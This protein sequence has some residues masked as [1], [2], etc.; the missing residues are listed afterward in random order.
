MKDKIIKFLKCK[1]LFTLPSKN[2]YLIY[3]YES[4]E[5]NE[6]IFKKLN[7]TY[8]HVRWE[9]IYVFLFL[10][11]FKKYFLNKNLTILQCYIITFIN[12]IEPK[13]VISFYQNDPFF[14]R[15]K[16][17]IKE[18]NISLTL[19]QNACIDGHDP[20][21][22]SFKKYKDLEID[23]LVTF[24]KFIG[25]EYQKYAKANNL[26]FG[27]LRNNYFK[28][29]SSKT[30]NE[31][32]IVYMSVFKIR[33]G[34]YYYETNKNTKIDFEALSLDT[35]RYL[36]SLIYKFSRE[37]NFKFAVLGRTFKPD[38]KLKE[39]AFYDSFLGKE[40]YEYLEKKRFNDSYY[41]LRQFK[42]FVFVSTTLGYEALSMGK[43]VACINLVGKKYDL[44]NGHEY[45]FQWPRK[46]NSKGPFWTDSPE[47][48][49][50]KNILTNIVSFSDSEWGELKKKYT[51]NYIPYLKTDSQTYE[52]LKNKGL[53]IFSN[54]KE[55]EKN[56]V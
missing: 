36:S 55:E 50:I 11:S 44:K 10:K 30:N 37:K 13:H 31:D 41:Y 34:K 45:R 25:K 32:T 54:Y 46:I 39:K 12:F 47:K 22:H 27:S 23:N 33:D 2:E 42:H 7:F 26:V 15:I 21:F 9:K 38:E 48:E 3:D 16:Q 40:N 19:F 18:K 43:R 1:F 6:F 49:E 35:D 8:L 24:D 5:P 17:F 53:N 56:Y 29:Y 28:D 4:L 14:W 20:T 51:D 52:Q